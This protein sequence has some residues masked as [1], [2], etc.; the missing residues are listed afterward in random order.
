MS[1]QPTVVSDDSSCIF[2]NLRRPDLN[3]IMQ[4][5][6]TFYVRYDNFPAAPGHVEVVPKRHVESFFELTAQELSDA[7]ALI[8][9]VQERI[10]KEFR[11]DG[12]TI[13]VNEGEAA[14]RTVHH[15]HIHVIPRHRGDVGDPRGGIRRVIPNCNPDLWTNNGSGEVGLK[16]LT[17]GPGGRPGR[18]PATA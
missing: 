16:E 17:A 7:Y 9:A 18:R 14:G 10:T 11:P 3:R 2:C 12:F 1:S 5:N 15:L 8:L 13:G 6:E 4:E